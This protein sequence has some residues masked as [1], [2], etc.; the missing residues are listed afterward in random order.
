MNLNIKNQHCYPA[1]Y[2]WVTW[3]VKAHL[4]LMVC[5]RKASKTRCCLIK[6][7]MIDVKCVAPHF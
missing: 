6:I 2:T 7:N 1:V 4:T 5:V 3:S